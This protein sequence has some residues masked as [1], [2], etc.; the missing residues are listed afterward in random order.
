MELIL[1]R[2][3]TSRFST[4]GQLTGV[5][6]FTF[7]TLEPPP[8]AVHPCIPVGRYKVIMA[9]SKKFHCLVPLLVDVPGRSEIE[10]H[11]GNYP[12]DTE[13]CI[14]VGDTRENAGM[15]LGTRDAC[16]G[17]VWPA[18]RKAVENNEEVWITV[19]EAV[20]V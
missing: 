12:S 8:Q 3:D 6:G 14:L 1:Q 5:E 7:Q 11:Y 13:G 18:V 20:N 16:Q 9:Q 4:P 19:K 2:S 10:I 17:H 15:I